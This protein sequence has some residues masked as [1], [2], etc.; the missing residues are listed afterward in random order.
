MPSICDALRPLIQTRNLQSSIDVFLLDLSTNIA[1]LPPKQSIGVRSLDYTS[2]K[3]ID[4]EHKRHFINAC[5]VSSVPYCMCLFVN[6]ISEH[7]H[8]WTLAKTNMR[9]E[10]C[11]IEICMHIYS[12]RVRIACR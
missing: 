6:Q 5:I 7:V 8:D 9:E 2:T 4:F 1:V 12:A 11:M 10:G 3:N